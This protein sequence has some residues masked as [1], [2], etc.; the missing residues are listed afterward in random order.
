MEQQG[1]IR[2]FRQLMWDYNIPVEDVEALLSGKKEKAGHYSRE[3][4]FKKMLESYSWY[5]ILQVFTPDEINNL[6]TDATINGLR[7]ATLKKKY[8]THYSLLI[9]HCSSLIAFSLSLMSRNNP[10]PAPSSNTP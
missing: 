6:L 10:S 5:T 1:K 4:L 9:A 2:L 8:E 7:T 3:T